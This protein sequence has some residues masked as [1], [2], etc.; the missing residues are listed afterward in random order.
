MRQVRWRGQ[1]HEFPDDATD[2]E[3][4]MALTGGSYID[5]E[6][7]NE[8]PELAT[9]WLADTPDSVQAAV[10]GAGDTLSRGVAGVQDIAAQVMGD[11][12]RQAEIAAQQQ[13]NAEAF[14]RVQE[15]FPIASTVGSVLPYLATAPLSGGL[16]TQAGLGFGLDALQ[17]QQDNTDRLAAGAEG[18]AWSALP[19]GVGR[20]YQRFRGG[21]TRLMSRADDL[22][23]RLTPGERLNSPMLRGLEASME[24]FPPTA[25]PMKA[26]RAGRQE[27][28]N[29]VAVEALGETGENLADDT[30]AGAASRIG[31]EFNQVIRK[32]TFPIDDQFV[33]ELANI[34][35]ASRRGV[36]GGATLDTPISR[37]LDE[38][39][40]G[41]VSGDTLQKWRTT[42][43]TDANK[44]WRSDT[45]ATEY[46]QGLDKLVDSIDGL[47]ARNLDEAQGARWAKAKEQ[48]SV[49][50][51]LEK[52]NAVDELGDVRGR[53]LANNLSRT[54]IGGYFRGQNTSDLYDAARLSRAYPPLAD[55]GTAARMSLP[56]MM[57]MAATSPLSVPAWG[58][59]NVAARAYTN[60]AT[61]ARVA[62][63]TAQGLAADD[64]SFME[65]DTPMPDDPDFEQD[66]DEFRGA[67]ASVL[68]EDEANRI[69]D[70]SYALSQWVEQYR[71]DDN[72][73]RQER[74]TAARELIEIL[75]GEG[76]ESGKASRLADGI[77]GLSQP[78][79]F[80][81]Y[82]VEEDD[83]SRYEPPLSYQQR[84]KASSARYRNDDDEQAAR[85]A[86]W[87]GM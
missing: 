21:P 3:I 19:F 80:S 23:F 60:P 22:G 18:A 36:M 34:E 70:T 12:Q 15:D 83:G 64:P 48:W 57:G 45:V 47:I 82:L 78:Q 31:E 24:S 54:D 58:A 49:L 76:V 16:A 14:S 61:A 9:G 66:L 52:A 72:Y 29:R 8:T 67:A 41:S 77:V 43:Q 71:G 84:Q 38:A 30:L 42:I 26:A 20:A 63:R 59:M 56:I 6:L 86:F 87:T 81:G 44:A 85:I 25:G 51:Q 65:S 50:K 37:I 27:V 2:R 53:K 40:E 68:G 55:S 69:A 74:R 75:R 4:A 7:G 32:R 5:T 73:S 11:E 10:L 35:E 39:S 33:D 28:M 17:Y 62:G 79:S 1:I 46:A 13:G